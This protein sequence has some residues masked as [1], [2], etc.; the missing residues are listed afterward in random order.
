MTCTVKIY[1][2]DRRT[3]SGYRFVRSAAHGDAA[4]AK[5][6]YQEH[7]PAP[8][9]KIEVIEMVTKKTIFGTT[10]TEPSDTPACCSPATETYWSM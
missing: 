9:W 6:V 2:Q 4:K 1:K 10:Y 3:K 5:I 7:Y 8:R